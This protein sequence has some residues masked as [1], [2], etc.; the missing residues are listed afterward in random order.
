VVYPPS[1]NPHQLKDRIWDVSCPYCGKPISWLPT[2]ED[3]PAKPGS[4]Y[5]LTKFTQ[6][7]LCR[8]VGRAF[9]I[10]ITVL[11]FFNVCGPGQ[12]PS[13]PYTGVLTSFIVK[14]LEG[15]AIDVYEDGGETRDF[16]HVQ[17]VVR[18]CLLALT[19][20]SA[21]WETFNVGT[22]I[23][24]SILELANLVSKQILCNASSKVQILPIARVGDIRHCVAD[25]RKA[26]RLLGFRADNQIVSGL[27]E[28]IRWVASQTPIDMSDQASRELVARGLLVGVENEDPPSSEKQQK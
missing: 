13:N 14:Y 28:L 23:A 19:N 10:P 20:D 9:G 26:Q 1:R 16:I 7:E 12:A 15:E 8:N 5:A 24:L 11:R 21:D 4:I 17:D 6:E 27:P 22:G 25:N 3:S 2:D 18:A